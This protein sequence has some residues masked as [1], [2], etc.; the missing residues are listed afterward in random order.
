MPYKFF[1]TLLESKAGGRTKRK[2]TLPVS[3]AIHL[4][5]LTAVVVVPLLSFGDLPDPVMSSA[6][7][8]YLVEAAPPPPPPPPPP[9]LRPRR[10]R[11]NR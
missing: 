7:R 10:P 11:R 6:I 5:V 1:D 8:A 9:R 2:L 3:I 4:V